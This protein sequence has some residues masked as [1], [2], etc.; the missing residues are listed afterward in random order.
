MPQVIP[1]TDTNERVVIL[2]RSR[3]MCRSMCRSRVRG[4]GGR[5]VRGELKEK[6]ELE[7]EYHVGELS[8]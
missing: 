1:D 7:R 4:R 6:I 5:V 3:S 2:G 8:Q